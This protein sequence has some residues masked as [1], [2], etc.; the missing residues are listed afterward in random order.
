M[1]TCV[2]IHGYHID[3][4]TIAASSAWNTL[5]RILK[6]LLSSNQLII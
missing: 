5:A 6:G 3:N 1:D 4:F 2:Y